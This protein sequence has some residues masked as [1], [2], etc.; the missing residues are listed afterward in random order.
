[1]LVGGTLSGVGSTGLANRKPV[2][3][4]LAARTL[5]KSRFYGA[6]LLDAEARIYRPG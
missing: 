5:R 4:I 1:M 3:G 2:P 6:S